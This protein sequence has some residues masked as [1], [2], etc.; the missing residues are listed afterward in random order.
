MIQAQFIQ[1][2]PVQSVRKA[3]VQL[4]QETPVPREIL[5]LHNSA[6]SQ[7]S[8]M[9]WER[10]MIELRHGQQMKTCLVHDCQGSSA[11]G[12]PYVSQKSLTRGVALLVHTCQGCQIRIFGAQSFICPECRRASCSIC[13]HNNGQKMTH[14]DRIHRPAVCSD[15]L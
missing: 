14:E 12:A 7:E 15:C 6:N 13:Y 3:S 9:D 4:I 8:W 5:E 10:T 2:T 1:E 11:C